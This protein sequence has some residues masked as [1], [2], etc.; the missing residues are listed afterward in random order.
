MVKPHLHSDLYDKKPSLSLKDASDKQHELLA[1]IAGCIK[2]D[3]LCQKKLYARFYNLVFSICLRY[4]KSREEAKSF[5]N[6]CFLKVFR[7]LDQYGERG[8]F[9][10]WLVRLSINVCLDQIKSRLSYQKQNASLDDL[11]HP[12]IDAD[13][14]NQLALQDLLN[15]IQQLP[16]THRS[17]FSLHVIDGY[18]HKEIAEM[19]NI[20]L[21][22]S[23]WYLSKAKELLKEKLARHGY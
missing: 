3:Y 12:A 20:S 18:K 23:R 6:L 10:G 22:T 17:V 11:F 9:E 21:G 2:D 1:L 8:A 14:I 4:T 7:K 16:D 5:V 13:V 15:I 19:L